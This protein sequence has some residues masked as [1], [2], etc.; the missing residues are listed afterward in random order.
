MTSLSERERA[1][2]AFALRHP[3]GRYD[4]T[5]TAQL[6]GVP[7]ST[8]Y[9][10]RRG[11]IY[12]SDYLRASPAIWSYRDLVML[13]LL[14]WLRQGGMARPTAAEKTASVREQ[15]SAGVE[16][17][18]IHATATDVVLVTDEGRDALDDRDN[19]LPSS[20]F[21]ALLGTFD[22]FEPI[23]ELRSKPSA[24]VWAP[25]LVT[26]SDHSSISPWV[27]AGDPCVEH[28]RIPT[29]AIYALRTERE[30]PV[31]AVVELYPGITADAVEDVTDLEGRLR[32]QR[33]A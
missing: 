23:E 7:R 25:N 26:P 5:R 4:A 16:I 15:L 24:A 33:A 20:D 12:N 1:T 14:A 17:R 29:A 11:G 9:D 22:L 32:D 6:S 28:S 19:L 2:I 21:Y 18:R 8:V 10:W 13:R 3:R 31:E 27:L 30:L